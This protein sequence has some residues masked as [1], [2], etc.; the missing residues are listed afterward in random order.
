MRVISFRERVTPGNK[1]A[2]VTSRW[3]I[4]AGDAGDFIAEENLKSILGMDNYR[5]LFCKSAV[6]D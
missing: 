4:Y 6:K 2:S 5:K 1:I 3:N